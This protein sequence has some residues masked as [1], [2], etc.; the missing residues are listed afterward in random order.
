MTKN[1]SFLSFI[2]VLTLFFQVNAQT[3]SAAFTKRI[4][5]VPL[6][7]RPPC[8][9]FTEKMGLIANAEL[10][11]PPKELLGIFTTPGQSEKINEWLLSQDLSQFD[12][13][14]VV[15]DMIAY[16]GL[17]ASR[18]HDTELNIALDR[19]KMVEELRKK[20]PKLKIYAQ[21]VVMRLAP[22]PHG[23]N[24]KYRLELAEWAHRCVSTEENHKLRTKEL[25]NIIPYEVLQDYKDA[26]HRNL[27]INL[28]AI[29]NVKKGNIDY[30]IL[31]QD[32]A[33]VEGIHVADREK[34]IQEAKEE[35]IISK[36]GV[37]PGADEVSMLLLS[38]ALTDLYKHKPTI[39]P[40][41]S[42]EI[43]AKKVMPFEDKPLHSTVSKHIDAAGAIETKDI[44]KA[45]VL[46]YVYTS[47]KEAGRGISF[48]KEIEEQI[49]KGRRI[50]VADIDPIGDVQGGDIVFSDALIQ[51]GIMQQ[52]HGYAS[53]NTAGNTIGTALPHGI[54][55][56]V[57]EKRLL[58][59][60]K[61]SAKVITAQNWFTI[62]RILDDYYFHNIVREQANELADQRKRSATILTPAKRKMLEEFGTIELQKYLDNLIPY[63]FE[64][65][66]PY[67]NKN[68]TCKRPSDLKF[69]LP[70]NR[71]FEG[72]VEFTLHCTN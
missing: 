44:E 20:G 22:T 60:K 32:D 5:F 46:F 51:N 19:M 41:Y 35:G 28:K 58:K 62:N 14:I 23:K 53:W 12:A 8:F 63:Y 3:T 45:D 48:A 37:Q 49:K 54:T 30:L 72:N 4:L 40:V 10:V 50:I 43:M 47:R 61:L 57:A 2:C 67:W 25:E 13:A 17:V 71:T 66:K 38:R 65:P 21:N 6:D 42:S 11:S 70:W 69:T 64:G 16:G 18:V 36:V 34:L 15:L 31:S 59:K 26:R 39:A 68:T 7:S 9:D 27:S 55:F 1:I 29:E 24:E 33:E 52:L 56:A